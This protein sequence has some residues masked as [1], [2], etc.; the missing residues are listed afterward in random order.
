MVTLITSRDPKG[1][2]LT[3]LFEAVVNKAELDDESAQRIIERGGE[4]QEGIGTL[5]EKL[6]RFITSEDRAIAI[7][8]KTKVVTASKVA[9]Y[10]GEHEPQQVLLPPED[11]LTQCARENEAGIADWRLVYVLGLS[12]RVQREIRGVDRKRQPCFYNNIWWLESSEDSWAANFA[13]P[14]YRLLNFKIQFTRK[15][16]QEQEEGIGNLGEDYERAHETAVAEAIQSV[17]MSCGECFL[18]SA[19]RR[20]HSLDSGRNRV[21]VAGFDAVGLSVSYYGDGNRSDFL[22][23]VLARKF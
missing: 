22:G 18:E 13:E 6:S 2:H 17:Y 1:L 12:L 9:G 19:Y 11:V 21:R 4:F 15:N 7:L 8:G 3:G 14:G 16:W 10:W 5:L 23:V 20:G